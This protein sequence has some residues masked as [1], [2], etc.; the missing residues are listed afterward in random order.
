M[1]KDL[2]SLEASNNNDV[3]MSASDDNH[4]LFHNESSSLKNKQ[5]PPP[6]DDKDGD[7]STA[8][9]SFFPGD[10]SEGKKQPKQDSARAKKKS[11]CKS[12]FPKRIVTVMLLGAN[13]IYWALSIRID[14]YDL[15]DC[16]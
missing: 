6:P 3:E 5:P 11:T 8:F 16:D 12:T 7:L 10:S 15:V 1:F 14:M 13:A 4:W 2:H 9:A